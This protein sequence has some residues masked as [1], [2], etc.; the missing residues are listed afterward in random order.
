MNPGNN[1][2]TTLLDKF[3]L[4][5]LTASAIRQRQFILEGESNGT[6]RQH[7]ADHRQYPAGSPQ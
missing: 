6:L 1:R 5:R 7:I 3:A 2:L 4:V